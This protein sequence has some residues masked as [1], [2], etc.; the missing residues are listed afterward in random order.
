MPFGKYRGEPVSQLDTGYLT[1][2]LENVPLRGALLSAVEQEV[3]AR[4][5]MR[6]VTLRIRASDADLARRVF[7]SGFRAVVKAVHPDAGGNLREMQRL[8][9]LRDSLRTQFKELGA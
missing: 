2:L 6:D 9:G 7:D 3:E 1:W 4:G 8:N 5:F